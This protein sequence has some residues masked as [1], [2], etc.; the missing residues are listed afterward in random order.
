MTAQFN[1]PAETRNAGLICWYDSTVR[2][3]TTISVESGAGGPYFVRVRT[4]GAITHEQ[5]CDSETAARIRFERA[6]ESHFNG[7]ALV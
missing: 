6:V 1:P 2:E 5:A 4:A 3:R 7:E